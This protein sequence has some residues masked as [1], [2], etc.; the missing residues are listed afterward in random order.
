MAGTAFMG[1]FADTTYRSRKCQ[2]RTL[3]NKCQ[4]EEY[5][6]TAE[7]SQPGVFRTGKSISCL[8]AGVDLSVS[9][10]KLQQVLRYRSQQRDL[11]SASC[12]QGS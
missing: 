4:T 7:L 3:E 12:L 8:E 1:S 6:G 9:C 2:L 5:K 10:T 11:S